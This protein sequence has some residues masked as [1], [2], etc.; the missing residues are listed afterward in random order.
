MYIVQV[1]PVM[2]SLLFS[3]DNYEDHGDENAHGVKRTM[4]MCINE[5]N[6]I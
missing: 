6:T 3:K 2:M 5:K 4:Q 1:W